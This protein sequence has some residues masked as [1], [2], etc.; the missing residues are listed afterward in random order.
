MLL[1]VARGASVCSGLCRLSTARGTSCLN[2]GLSL[3]TLLTEEAGH[4]DLTGQSL[5][6]L[7]FSY[8]FLAQTL[9]L[10]SFLFLNFSLFPPPTLSLSNNFL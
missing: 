1:S 10:S 8:S 2:P 3:H 7:S 9:L 6:F 4:L 5:S